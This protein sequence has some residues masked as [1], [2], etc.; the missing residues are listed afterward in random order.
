MKSDDNI[1]KLPIKDKYASILKEMYSTENLKVQE[2]GISKSELLEL[3]E[4][5]EVWEILSLKG[6]A[7]KNVFKEEIADLKKKEKK[8]SLYQ[9][10]LFKRIFDVICDV[11]LSKYIY[12][13]LKSPGLKR[14]ALFD[15]DTIVNIASKQIGGNP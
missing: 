8:D 4:I 7:L 14:K 2:N 11:K 15:F 10:P 3:C 1:I 12:M 5:P 9:D 13:I 6:L